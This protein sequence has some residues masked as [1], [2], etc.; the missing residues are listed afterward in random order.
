MYKF[1]EH[2]F[3]HRSKSPALQTENIFNKEQKKIC[4]SGHARLCRIIWW[5]HLNFWT[6]SHF[7]SKSCMGIL[8]C[9]KIFLDQFLWLSKL[10]SFWTKNVHLFD[11][12]WL[13]VHIGKIRK[14]F[15]R[16]K[17]SYYFEVQ[18]WENRTLQRRVLYFN[19]TSVQYFFLL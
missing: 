3:R 17:M 19:C 1:G 5:S 8:G 2:L 9:L 12:K 15:F 11:L 7:Q 13:T 10:D 18:S 14:F 4:S 16:K 6:M